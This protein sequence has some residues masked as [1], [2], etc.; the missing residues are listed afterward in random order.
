[1]VGAMLSTAIENQRPPWLRRLYL[2]AYHVSDAARYAGTHPNTV[3]SWH[4]RDSPLLP[5]HEHRRPLSYLE[6]VEVAFVA[7]FR[8]LHIPMWRIRRARDYVAQN[9]TAQ[10]P[11]AQYRFKTEGMHILMEY[12]QFDPDPNIDRIIVAD[13]WGQLAWTDLLEKKFAEFDYEY[14]LALRWHPAGRES[15]VIIDPR[16]SFG[17]PVVEGLPTWVL[18]GRWNAGESI[19]EILEEFG[20]SQ[21]AAVDALHFENIAEVA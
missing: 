17:A 15:L 9:F 11:L 6:L 19:K 21:K 16:V 8:R 3:A 20:I 14:E 5:G 12:N 10:Y 18:K 2:P 13:Q 7:F 4:Y 1:M